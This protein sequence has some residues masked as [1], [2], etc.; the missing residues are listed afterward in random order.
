MSISSTSPS[1]GV[2]GLSAAL[3]KGYR[4][5]TTRSIGA[6][7]CAR[8]RREIVGAVSPRQD[9]GKH[10]RVKRLDPAVHHFGKA[11]HV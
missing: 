6:I 9:A 7:P 3:P 4:L 8:E 2:S 11:G 10:R 1:N 5:T